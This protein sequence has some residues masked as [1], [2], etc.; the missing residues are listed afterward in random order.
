MDRSATT[1]APD[2]KHSRIG[3]PAFPGRSNRASL[4]AAITILAV[5]VSHVVGT[6]LAAGSGPVAFTSHLLA[7][8]PEWQAMRGARAATGPGLAAA[9]GNPAAIAS[10]GGGSAACTHLQW[11]GGLAREW[12]SAGREF[13]HGIALAVDAAVLRAPELPGYDVD[14]KSTGPFQ[15]MEWDLGVHGA[16]PLGRGFSAGIGARLFRL[17]DEAE[18]LTGA[19]F[20]VGMQMCAAARRVGLAL[21]D[22]GAPLRGR[23]GAYALPTRWRAGFEQELA[24]GRVLVAASL[25]S[26][27]SARTRGAF[28]LV[29]RPAASLE[30]LGGVLAGEG[31]TE[32]TPVSWSAGA[33]VHRGA[34]AVS[35][36]FRPVDALGSTHLVGIRLGWRGSRN[37][38][39]VTARSEP[40]KPHPA[41]TVERATPA[42]A[43]AIAPCHAVYGGRYRTADAA[44]AEVDLLRIKGMPAARAVSEGDGHWRVLVL[45]CR[46][47]EEAGAAVSQ[48]RT[49]TILATAEPISAPTPPVGN[50]DSP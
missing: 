31:G 21:T 12:A 4:R 13:D 11:A 14:G 42:E 26:E 2:R 9:L 16:L 41:P 38:G 3:L 37:L 45:E 22:A 15:T 28:G 19:G 33:T 46:T 27:G 18:P 1:P 44:R 50:P 34:L 20:S 35:Y 39:G 29:A 40:G 24:D 17:E 43:G 32:E 47:P 8:D 7:P 5:L 36:A 25:E 49:W 23:Q 10:L 6:G 48:L 30:L